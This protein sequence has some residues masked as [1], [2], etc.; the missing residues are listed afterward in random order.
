MI[1]IFVPKSIETNTFE[2]ADLQQN[3]FFNPQT[4]T[5]KNYKAGKSRIKLC[6]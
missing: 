2:V 1:H 3:T 4:E 6:C 5:D